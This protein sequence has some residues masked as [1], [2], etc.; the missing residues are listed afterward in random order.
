LSEFPEA[1][2]IRQWFDEERM[3]LIVPYGSG[4]TFLEYLEQRGFAD[5]NIVERAEVAE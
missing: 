3:T 1:T 2:G 5:A 4:E